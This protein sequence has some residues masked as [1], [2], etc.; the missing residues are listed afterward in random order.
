MNRMKCAIVITASLF[1]IVS[2][3][4]ASAQ[5]TAGQKRYAAWAACR[6]SVRKLR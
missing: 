2:A 1:G 6:K 3:L 4:P 5:Q